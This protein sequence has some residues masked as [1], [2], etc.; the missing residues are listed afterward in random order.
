MTATQMISDPHRRALF[1]AY[2]L[3]RSVETSDGDGHMPVNLPELGRAFDVP[4]P[5]A[6]EVLRRMEEA[7]VLSFADETGGPE[8]G[9][10]IPRKGDTSVSYKD[11]QSIHSY[12]TILAYLKFQ[13]D[14][15]GKPLYSL[16]RFAGILR[17]GSRHS[18]SQDP[19]I[20]LWRGSRFCEGAPEAGAGESA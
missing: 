12:E 8:T 5:E 17:R 2:L 20:T 15:L 7:G 10:A 11:R 18:G 16:E 4:P 6:R 1:A 19:E 3:I 13:R 9:G 14:V